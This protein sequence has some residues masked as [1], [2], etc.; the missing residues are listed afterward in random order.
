MINVAAETA[1]AVK[2]FSA[3]IGRNAATDE[4]KNSM[5]LLYRGGEIFSSAELAGAILTM[6][7]T[8]LNIAQFFED[9][10]VF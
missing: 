6:D 5:H 3:I 2:R 10:D 1:N 9:Y 4:L 7:L 8:R